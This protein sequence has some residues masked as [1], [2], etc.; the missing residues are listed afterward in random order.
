VREDLAFYSV[1]QLAALLRK[2]AI[3]SV[4]LTDF[5]LDRLKRYDEKLHCVISF[6]E[7]RARQAAAQADAELAM[8]IDRGILHGIPYG[9]KDPASRT[10]LSYHLG[11]DPLQRANLRLYSYRHPETRRGRRGTSGK[12]DTGSTS[13][14]RCMVRR[15]DT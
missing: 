12:A 6:T 2:G 10:G 15:D 1:L 14:G 7:G 13:L 5:F 3:T 9:A 11:S 8:G 4:A